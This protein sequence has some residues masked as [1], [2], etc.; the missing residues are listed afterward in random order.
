MGRAV[1]TGVQRTRRASWRSCQQF[2]IGHVD[3]SGREKCEGRIREN[4]EAF[5]TQ[6]PK[7]LGSVDDC[8]WF[9]IGPWRG[10]TGSA[11]RYPFPSRRTMTHCK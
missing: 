8:T 10:D 9:D 2:S 3:H 11:V 4:I 1:S 7:D 5:T 6:K